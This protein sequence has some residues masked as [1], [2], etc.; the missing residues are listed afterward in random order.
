M[1]TIATTTPQPGQHPHGTKC[2]VI[3]QSQAQTA[4]TARAAR[5]ARTRKT[6][7]KVGQSWTGGACAGLCTMYAW[8]FCDV[9]GCILWP[10]A[11]QWGGVCILPCA[12][13]QLSKPSHV[14][15][16]IVSVMPMEAIAAWLH[17]WDADRF[18]AHMFTP[19]TYAQ[20]CCCC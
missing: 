7:G 10:T 13:K 16:C 17:V 20:G 4:Q 8:V 5:Q 11:C 6:P 9:G 12:C 2:G 19:G 3:H 15:V 1:S 14:C 18:H